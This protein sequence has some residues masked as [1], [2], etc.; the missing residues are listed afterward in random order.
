VAVLSACSR[1]A[2]KTSVRVRGIT[3]RRGAM[4]LAA[5]RA[6]LGVAVLAAPEQVTAGWLGEEN[7]QLPVVGDLARSLGARDVALGIAT[8]Q[9]LE[10]PVVGPRVQLVCALVDCADVLATV[11]ARASLPRKGLYGTVVI[12][13]AAAGAGFYCSHKLAHA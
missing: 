7:A 12:A 1:T 11:I 5:G 8:L 13:G 9:T 10:D 6:A 3:P 4:L 2:I